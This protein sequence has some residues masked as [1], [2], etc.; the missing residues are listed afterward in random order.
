MD[1]A[2][3]LQYLEAM[4]IDVWQPIAG[5]FGAASGFGSVQPAAEQSHTVT[6]APPSEKDDQAALQALPSEPDAGNLLSGHGDIAEADINNIGVAPSVSIADMDWDTLRQTVAECRNCGLCEGRT[7]TVFGVGNKHAEWMLIGEGPGQQEDLQG[8][9][10]VGKAGQLL[11]E[12][13]RAMGLA[14]ED[15]YIANVVKCRPPNNRDPKPEEMAAC[16]VYLR[17]QIEL[18]RPKMLLALGRI[19]AQ[20]LLQ[21]DAPLAKLRR[22]VYFLGEIPLIVIYHPAYLLRSLLEKRKAWDDL[23]MAL[24]VFRERR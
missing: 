4:G 8:E 15:V 16:S 6:S 17:R 2:R 23:Q 10:F 20:H 18:L 21:T 5:R 3:R 22:Q 11:N 19:A 14:R 13:L 7:Q 1:E 9:P 24:R 12:M